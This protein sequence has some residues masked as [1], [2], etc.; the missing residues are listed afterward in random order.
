MLEHLVRN[1]YERMGN[2]N[3]IENTYLN[4]YICKAASD[5]D[6]S[7]EDACWG[8]LGYSNSS[9]TGAS[10]KNTKLTS[11]LTSY[12]KAR[13]DAIKSQ[14][15][16]EGIKFSHINPNINFKEIKKLD[17][18]I[19]LMA[20]YFTNSLDLIMC[21]GDSYVFFKDWLLKNY[22][23]SVDSLYNT[24][25]E[26][27]CLISYYKSDDKYP[28]I[29]NGALYWNVDVSEEELAKM[30]QQALAVATHKH[31]GLAWVLS[32]KPEKIISLSATD[33]DA[34]LEVLDVCSVLGITYNDLLE[35]ASMR[36][37]NFL[38]LYENTGCIFCNCSDGL[39]FCY[40]KSWMKIKSSDLRANMVNRSFDL[41]KEK[42]VIST[43]NKPSG[44]AKTTGS[45]Q[46]VESLSAFS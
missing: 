17:P 8:L 6:I 16:V 28:V 1:Y 37:P 22:N 29:A 38:P 14:K 41:P 46:S 42:I 11:S 15:T 20:T 3:G 19:K 25:A 35:T 4:K 40:D 44:D 45:S 26:N 21:V 24:A 12:V 27:D 23:K 34:Y 33:T 13:R 31:D 43:F 39:L 10:A 18:V 7:F 9:L 36:V 5:N 2:F 30:N 32:K